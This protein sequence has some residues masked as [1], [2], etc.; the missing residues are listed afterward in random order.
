M[1]NL[2]NDLYRYSL[3]ELIIKY[4]NDIVKYYN[5]ALESMIN[6]R[7]DRKIIS[8]NYG[9]NIYSIIRLIESEKVNNTSFYYFPNHEIAFYPMY[10]EYKASRPFSCDISSGVIGVGMYYYAYRPLIE[11]LDTGRRYVLDRTLKVEMSYLDVLPLTFF[12]FEMLEWNLINGYNNDDAFYYNM[13]SNVGNLRL[14]ELKR[15]KKL[16]K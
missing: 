12:D 6:N 8:D 1:V 9:M 13:Y 7:N 2:R 11:D 3:D 4:G 5:S 14:K 16:L 15:K 10:R